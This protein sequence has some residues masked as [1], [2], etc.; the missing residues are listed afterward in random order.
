MTPP[1]PSMPKG[2]DFYMLI[3]QPPP[4]CKGKTIVMLTRKPRSKWWHVACIGQKSHYRKDDGGCAHTDELI[5]SLNPEAV[6]RERVRLLG[7]GNGTRS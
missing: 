1:T 2:G 5:A 6:P 4:R 7:F 3:G